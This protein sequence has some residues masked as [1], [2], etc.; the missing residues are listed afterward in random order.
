MKM[1]ALQDNCIIKI[2]NERRIWSLLYQWGGGFHEREG[3]KPAELAV[4]EEPR[5]RVYKLIAPVGRKYWIRRSH[6]Q[7]TM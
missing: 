5:A 1:K 7:S 4:D 2:E 3:V 6:I